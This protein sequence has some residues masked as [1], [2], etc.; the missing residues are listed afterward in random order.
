MHVLFYDENYKYAGED[1]I[2]INIEE[3]EKLPPNSTTTPIPSG[4]YVPKYDPEKDEWIESATKEYIESVT[5][6]DPE[7]NP[8]ELLKKQN[9]LLS[10]QIAKLQADVSALKGGGAS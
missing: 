4:L 3:G 9:A 8:T 2:E 5:P 10:L 6:P 7:P 1:D